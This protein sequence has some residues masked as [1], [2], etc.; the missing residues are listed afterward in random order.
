MKNFDYNLVSM[1]VNISFIMQS[2]VT[3][4]LSLD[5]VLIPIIVSFVSQC[6]LLTVIIELKYK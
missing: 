6:L 5:F 1:F 4:L 2:I 3:L